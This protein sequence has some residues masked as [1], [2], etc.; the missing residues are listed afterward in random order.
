MAWA[1]RAAELRAL[2]AGPVIDARAV[3]ELLALQS[4][5]W[6]FLV[7]RDLA[8]PYGRERAARHC[9]GLDAALAAPGTRDPALRNLA[10][11]AST[12]AL[13]EP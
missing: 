10:P 13:L 4:S 2:A 5:D 7:S 12:A 9:A 8:A 11:D 3:R 1:A 6:S